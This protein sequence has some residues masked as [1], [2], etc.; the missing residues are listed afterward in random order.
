V[1]SFEYS[2]DRYAPGHYYHWDKDEQKLD[3]H[4]E[5]MEELKKA[6]LTIFC[7]VQLMTA[8]VV[9]VTDDT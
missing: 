8:G 3:R 5:E 9:H 1:C 6:G 7:M 4:Q 2:L